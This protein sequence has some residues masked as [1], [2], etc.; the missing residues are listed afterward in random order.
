MNKYYFIFYLIEC[1]FKAGNS[2]V[3]VILPKL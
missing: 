3:N 2:V 1:N